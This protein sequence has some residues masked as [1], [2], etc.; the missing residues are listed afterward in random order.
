MSP[1]WRPANN[2]EDGDYGKDVINEHD[3]VYAFSP[4]GG[5]V[6]LTGRRDA[7]RRNGIREF[8][9]RDVFDRSQI[10]EQLKCLCPSAV[11]IL[12]FSKVNNQRDWDGWAYKTS[13][14]CGEGVYL[15]KAPQWSEH[16]ASMKEDDIKRWEKWI[17]A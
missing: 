2:W 15:Y 10:C 6:F 17:V 14:S 4:N 11:F 13:D 8:E 7:R 16:L 1:K 12:V 9:K 3:E 5:F